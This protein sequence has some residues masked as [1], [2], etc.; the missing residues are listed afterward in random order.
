MADRGEE[1]PGNFYRKGIAGD[2]MNTFTE[3]DKRV[4]KETA[5]DLLVRLGYEF[6]ND[7]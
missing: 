6:D 5:G 3:K 1:D 2:W 7:W 4:Y